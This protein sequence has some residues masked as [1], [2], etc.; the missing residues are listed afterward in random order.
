M[1]GWDPYITERDKRLFP[2]TGYG[3]RGGFGERPVLLVIDVSYA[4]TGDGPEPIFESIKRWHNSAGEEAWRAITQIQRLIAA[5]R[6]RRLPIFYTTGP[7]DPIAGD[8]GMGR[9]KDKCGRE[10][11]DLEPARANQIVREIEPGP[12]DVVIEKGKSSAF[13]GT[14]LPSYLADLGADSIITCGVATSGCVRASVND[15]FSYN[16]RMIVVE[17]GTFDRAEASH[18]VNL[19]DMHMKYADVLGIDE[20]L[21]YI[22]TLPDDLF[23]DRM[24]ILKGTAGGAPPAR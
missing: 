9:W 24:P 7:Q 4:F 15:G 11:E 19:F 21:E 10:A 12:A 20:V 6:E 16:Y 5:S 18:W 2:L 22:G 1:S 17:E 8:F 14:L 13:F 3:E 23:V